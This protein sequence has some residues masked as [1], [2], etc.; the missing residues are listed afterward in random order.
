MPFILILLVG[1]HS[2]AQQTESLS[3]IDEENWLKDKYEELYSLELDNEKEEVNDLIINRFEKILT[4][5]GSF[6]YPFDSLLRIGKIWSPDQ[7]IRLITWNIPQSDGTHVY[8]GFLQYRLKK[9]KSHTLIRLNDRSAEIKQPE[10]AE[11]SADNWFGAL[12]YDIL[13]NKYA[14]K[15]YYT[16]LALDYNDL[17]SHKKLVDVLTFTSEGRPVFGKDIFQDGNTI[18]KRIIF[19]Y[20]PNVAMTLRYNN[21]LNMIVFDHLSPIEPALEGNF[22]FYAP[23]LSFDG[24]EFHKGKWIYRADLD[25]RNP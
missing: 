22:K 18:Q 15:K 1:S 23:D 17:F 5:Q 12:Y 4:S 10:L 2:L 25:V 24:L 11:L 20:S 6:D 19:E 13:L 16:L 7:K 14:R 3:L 9:R 8:Y 21:E